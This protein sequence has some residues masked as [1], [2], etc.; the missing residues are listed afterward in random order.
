[1]KNVFRV[2]LLFASGLLS[3]SVLHAQV[4]V[5]TAVAPLAQ[6]VKQY[7]K[8]EAAITLT[9][10]WTNPYDYDNIRVQ[11]VVT[12]PD[13]QQETIDGFFMQDYQITNTQTGTISV[14]GAGGFK[15]RYAPTQTGVYQYM[16][17]CTTSA[18]TGS[19]PTQTFTCETPDPLSA[20]GFV[21]ADQTNY[22]HFDNG[23]QYIPVG[24]N[25]AWQQSNIY[26]DYQNWLQKLS[27]NGGNFIRL[28]LCHWGIG[29]EWKANTNGYQGLRKYQQSNAFYLDW[30]L[31]KCAEKGVY[32]MLCL[33]HHG[34][35]SSQVNPNWNESPYNT[36]NGG[37]CANT[38]DFF[39]N[40]AAK[41]SLKNRLRYTVARW[42]YQRSIMAWE[43]FNEV[44]W[45]DQFDQRK[46]DVSAWHLEMSAYLKQKDP[47]QHLVTTSYAHDYNDQETWNQPDIDLTQ[48]HYYVDVPNLERALASGNTQYLNDYGKPTLNG[49]FGLGGS[50]SGLS[51][52]DPNGIHV[53]NALWGGLFSGGAG[54]GMQWW[55]DTYVNQQNLYTHFAGVSAVAAVLPLQAANFQ[56]LSAF[57]AGAPA[58]LSLTP[59]LGWGGLADTEI[60]I[61]TSGTISPAGAKLGQ[62]L[63]GS[64]WNTQYRRPPVFT[65]TYPAAGQFLVKTGTSTGQLP[66]ISIWID[67]VQ[68]LNQNGA[69]NQ[70]YSVNVPAGNHQIQ[71]DNTGTDWISIAS[72]TFSGLGSAIDVYALCAEDQTQMAGWVLHNQYNHQRVKTSG[73]PNP[74]DGAVLKITGLVNGAY[75][76]H[77]FNCLTGA[78]TATETVQKNTDTLSI[79]VPSLLWDAV[80]SLTNQ[81]VSTGDVAIQSFPTEVYPNPV[82]AGTMIKTAF[83]LDAPVRTRVTLLDASGKALQSIFEDALPAGE[84]LVQTIMPENL[85]AGIYWVKI[86]AGNKVAVKGVGVVR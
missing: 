56:P 57:A 84:Q 25:M 5:I 54:T 1:M 75:Q 35:V 23:E 85:A 39:T 51:T 3:Q 44:D 29:L 80:F 68:V 19:F 58:D 61:T 55:W 32:V 28:W 74:V 16:V 53:H 33:N 42:G 31:D 72:Y 37:P 36:A 62:Y 46:A 65:V 7:A 82:N 26:Q 49:E 15:I 41:A 17:S 86:E 8:F 24:E 14:L 18:G 77:W 59:S 48:T 63:Y 70:T 34:Q 60:S 78:L 2:V 64:Q 40:S 9:A 67:G 6:T 66:K 52:L 38:W 27:S 45:T 22:L 71:V 81:T 43:L 11:A 69:V 83:Y 10:S 73:Q 12:R 47:R 4:P 13:G 79:P 30:L 21:R 20:K 76:L 50:A